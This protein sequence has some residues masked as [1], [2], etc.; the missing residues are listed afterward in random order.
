MKYRM[1]IIA[2]LVAAALLGCATVPYP[3]FESGQEV[4]MSGSIVFTGVDGNLYVA[5]DDEIT[6]VA[7]GASG[8]FRYAAYAW[9]G[10][11]VVYATQEADDAGRITA[12]L[13]IVEPGRRGRTLFTQP[14]LA[15]FFLNPTS[16]GTRV[17]YLGG[18]E[19]LNDFIM[20]SVNLETGER[21][22][23]GRGQPFYATWSPDGQSLVTHIGAP[24]SAR[25]SILGLQTMS[26]LADLSDAEL[27]SPGGVDVPSRPLGLATGFFQTPE[28]N[29][30][31]S[32][33]A[34]ILSNEESSGIHLLDR[35]GADL[36]RLVELEGDA[37]S[38]AWNPNG[39]RI[40]YTD[41]FPTRLGAL[42]G[43]L[44]IARLGAEQPILVSEQATSHFWSPDGTK[45]LYFEPYVL[46]ERRTLGYRVG[47]Y[48]L[49]DRESRIVAVMRP[50]P[51]F[52]STIVPFVDQ[53]ER[54]YT[55][56]SPDSRL[57]ALNSRAA[58]GEDVIHLLD[59]ESFATR[60]AFRVSYTPVQQENSISLGLLPA[61]GVITRALTAG[62]IPFFQPVLKQY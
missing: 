6:L 17:G 34:V 60:D 1:A 42:V 10:D 45:L 48:Y 25:G 56:W 31:G 55:L 9:A 52:T 28:F 38:M 33:I 14:G 2:V 43:R 23:H 18:Q 37:A 58:N 35:Q 5:T 32:Q 57:V 41:G 47:I 46:P 61:E 26:E 24:V 11:R 51:A 16:D 21:T 12:S 44:F 30:D 15:P 49:A 4:A 22:L 53:Y 39:S 59:T 40:A 8:S 3:M 19:G 29:P 7:G 36:G 50:S 27:R 54:A 62:S 20:G 13:G